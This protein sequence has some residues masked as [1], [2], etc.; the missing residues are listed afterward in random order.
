[1]RVKLGGFL[2]KVDGMG[3][4]VLL[5]ATMALAL[6]LAGGGVA[7]AVI[8]GQPDRPAHPYVGLAYNKQEW[9]TGALI[10]PRVF[11]TLGYCTRNFEN[12][13]FRTKVYVTFERR[14][15][16]EPEFSVAGVPHTHP[17]QGTPPDVGVVVL[18]EPVR[19]DD[20][21]AKLPEANLVEELPHRA[22]L[23]A[24]GYDTGN[25]VGCW[26]FC[27]I[28]R[29]DGVAIR[30]RAAREYVGNKDFDSPLFR[31]EDWYIKTSQAS[32]E[33]GRGGTCFGSRGIPY[34]LASDQRTIVAIDSYWNR[35]CS[36]TFMAERIDKPLVLNWVRTF[37]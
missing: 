7:Q 21:Y 23:T 13:L 6:L 1:M 10:S 12:S 5:S 16:F 28:N 2:G 18:D 4:T 26:Q 33:E 15:Y 32:A 31:R 17:Q 3:R 20:G 25:V 30:Y 9:C 22:D 24:V 29:P 19:T 35:P 37:L 27:G 11:L 8:G 36:G 14:T 34:F